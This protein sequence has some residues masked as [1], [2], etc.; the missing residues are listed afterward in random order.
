MKTNSNR[1]LQVVFVQIV[2][3]KQQITT[4][5]TNEN[6]CKEYLVFYYT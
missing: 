2:S 4:T 3:K 6:K 1:K 5:T